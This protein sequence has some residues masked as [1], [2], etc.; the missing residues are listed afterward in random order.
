MTNAQDTLPGMTPPGAAE[1]EV[2]RVIVL[3]DLPH[4]DHPLDYYV[5]D[6]LLDQAVVGAGVT[7]TVGGRRSNGWIV[8]RARQVPSVSRL[9]P[10]LRV[11][12]RIPVLTDALLRVARIIADK[13]VATLSQTLSIAVPAIH[14]A[15]EKDVYAQHATALPEPQP[16]NADVWHGFPGG[17]ALAA[18]LHNAGNPRAVWTALRPRRDA[19]L[20]ALIG[21]TIASG[22]RA[23]VVTPTQRDA[24]ALH[25]V[26]ADHFSAVALYTG[27][28]SPAERYATYLRAKRGDFHVLVGTRS[29][30]WCQVPQL[31]L[32]IVWDDADDH[33]RERRHPCTDA[34]EV[35]VTRSHTQGCALVVGA[36]SR[37]TRAQ[38]LIRSGW[39]HQVESDLATR[40]ALN[41]RVR[42]Q[43]YADIEREGP[44]AHLRLSPLVTRTIKAGLAHGPVLVHVP[45]AGYVGALVCQRCRQGVRCPHCTGPLTLTSASCAVCTWCARSADAWRCPQCHSS[46]WVHIRVGSQRTGEELGK[47]FPGVPLSV[48]SASHEITRTIDARPRLV[49]A[50]PGAEPQ[51][52]DGYAAVV[53]LDAPAIAGRSELWAPEEAVRRWAHALSLARP[54]APA[55]IAGGVDSVLAQTLIRGDYT[56][57]AQR[58]LDERESLQYFPAATIVAIDGAN[59]DVLAVVTEAHGELLGTVNRDDTGV[60]SLIRFSK[61]E[62]AAGLARLKAIQQRRAARKLTLVKITVNPP[63]LF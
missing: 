21:A 25:A 16:F 34:L 45:F 59:A 63:E 54:Q 12:T 58:A 14:V 31:G 60:R 50:T 48:S 27:Q 20:V 42:V 17:D 38:A 44:A 62:A 19:Q 23:I 2:A 33:L 1:V 39:A 9:Q 5:P 57:F 11:T 32:I 43:D 40:R 55:L 24:E 61:D 53:I 13:H 36:W 56:G 51:A 18:H 52:T 35:A 15:A 7:V 26:I 47:A 4:L 49:V 6:D 28:L 22:R 10:L 41:A 30:V 3:T 29:S 37:S 8:E 46:Q